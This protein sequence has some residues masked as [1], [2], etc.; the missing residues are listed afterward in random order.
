MACLR[1]A[2][3]DTE[4]RDEHFGVKPSALAQF[5]GYLPTSI[6][7]TTSERPHSRI[8]LRHCKGRAGQCGPV[9][10]FARSHL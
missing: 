8:A 4:V 2:V 5:A 3:S 6:T 9:M 10:R 7:F 1:A